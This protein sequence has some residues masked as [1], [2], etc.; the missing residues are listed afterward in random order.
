M[1]AVFRVIASARQGLDT[2]LRLP[3]LEHAF[4]ER[5]T[6]SSL[7]LVES[8]GSGIGGIRPRPIPDP[9]RLGK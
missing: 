1:I 4:P 5:K 7:G 6:S 9:T 3:K 2:V 8:M